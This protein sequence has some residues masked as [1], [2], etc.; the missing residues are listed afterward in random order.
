MWTVWAVSLLQMIGSATAPAMNIIK[1][2]VFAQYPF[3]QI[4]TVMALSGL[5]SPFVSLLTAELIRRGLITK[6]AVVLGG[7][8]T[9]GATGFLALILNTQ[10]WHLGLLSILT[11]IASGCYLSTVLS[12]MVDKF[13]PGERQVVTGFQSVFVNVGGFLIS[14][15]G[16]L[17]AAWRWYGGYM[18]LLVGIPVGIMAFLTLPREEKVRP[19]VGTD[20]A[21]K[22]KFEP[23]IFFYAIT[24]LIFMLLFSVI[25][26]NLAVHM[27]ASGFKNPAYV[28]VIT[29]V[30]MAGGMAFGFVFPKL[31]RL[32]KDN[33][34]FI[35]YFMLAVGFSILNLFHSSLV[36]IGVGVFLTGASMSLIGPHCVVAVSHCVDARTSALATSLVTG[37]A[38]GLGSFLSPVI[39]TNLTTVLGG[40]STNFR[41]QFVGITA[42]A[43]GIVLVAYMTVRKH[44]KQTAGMTEAHQIG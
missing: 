32:Y 35:A 3:S 5:V 10:L 26:Q 38:P 25:N 13:T 8:F 44:R 30:Q 34:L 39:F 28:G 42:L 29:A 19:G 21:V 20:A 17:L 41:Y 43:G 16:G 23:A 11:G 18:I 37:L 6:K 33:L 31:T 15:S 1:T 40:E 22:A 14:V 7:L 24:V 9:L 2:S 12:I 27:A 4:Q 36:L